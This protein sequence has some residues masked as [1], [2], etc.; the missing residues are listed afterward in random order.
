MKEQTVSCRISRDIVNLLV[1]RGMTP[2][3]LASA[4]GVTRSF[5]SR[6][7]SGTRNF[8]LN[9]LSVLEELVGESLPILLIEAIPKEMVAPE[10]RPIH[11]ACIR[12]LETTGAGRRGM[13]REQSKK[14][15]AGTKAA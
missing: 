10:H 8:T 2:L 12:L 4:L 1:N 11:E 7:K 6:V 13:R 5:I 3:Q 9:H 14:R 15:R